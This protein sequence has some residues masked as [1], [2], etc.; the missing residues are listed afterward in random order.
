MPIR[1]LDQETQHSGLL[2]RVFTGK[3]PTIKEKWEAAPK[4]ARKKY[5]H[6]LISKEGIRRE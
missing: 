2:W 5:K 6:W 3:T 4:E 1:S